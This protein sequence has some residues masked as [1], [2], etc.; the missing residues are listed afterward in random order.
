MEKPIFK[1]LMDYKYEFGFIK[2][3]NNLK[4]STLGCET[5][6]IKSEK[7]ITFNYLLF[8]SVARC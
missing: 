7:L 8:D 2:I 1:Q 6:Q 4:N 5:N 3:E